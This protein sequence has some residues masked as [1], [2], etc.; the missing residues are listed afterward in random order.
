MF[1]EVVLPQ[2]VEALYQE[3]KDLNSLGLG[4]LLFNKVNHRLGKNCVLRV[5]CP[6]TV[7]V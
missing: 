6:N 7:G 5:P 3:L 2:C 4:S 1:F